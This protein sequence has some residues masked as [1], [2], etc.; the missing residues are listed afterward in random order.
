M[1]AEVEALL[2]QAE[3]VD[4]AED[5]FRDCTFVN[6]VKLRAG[7]NPDFFKGTAMER[8]VECELMAMES[9]S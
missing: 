6:P 7:S 2:R 9:G 3:K 5:D 8:E 1:E 4:Q